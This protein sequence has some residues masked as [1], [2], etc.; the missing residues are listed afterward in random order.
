MRK[1][2][3]T[4]FVDIVSSSGTPKANK[5]LEIKK[6]DEYHPAFDYYKGIRDHIIEVHSESLPKIEIKNG[7]SKA[8]HT[9][10][11]GNYAEIADAYYSWLGKKE[12][13]WFDPI[14]SSFERHGVSVSVNPEL[15]LNINGTKHLVKLY[16]KP[17]KLAKNRIDIIS[18]LMSHCL[19][20]KAGVDVSM[21]I[22]DIR[23]KKLFTAQDTIDLDAVLTAELAYVSSLLG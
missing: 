18:Y 7:V 21:S 4:D 10:K 3:L 22:L 5:V 12:I 8:N 14:T 16:F 1:I 13:S 23:N 11:I 17:D 9:N 20:K 19:G 6:R 15:G 2:S